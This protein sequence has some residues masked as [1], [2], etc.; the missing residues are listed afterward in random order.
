MPAIDEPRVQPLRHG[1]SPLAIVCFGGSLPFSVADAALKRGCPV[2]L[3]AVRGWADG[4]AVARYPHAWVGLGQFGRMKRL[5]RTAGCGDVVCIGNVVRPS[6]RELRLDWGAIRL[7]P[8][9][10]RLFRGGDDH[11]LSGIKG[12]MEE[13]GFRVLGAHEVAPEILVQ[14]GPLSRKLPSPQA[15]ADA[16]RGFALLEAI[17]AFDV[18]QAVVVAENRVL[19][20][21][22]ADGTDAMLARIAE[23]RAA[24]RIQLPPGVGVLVKAPKSGQDHRM[25]LPS[26]GPETV[27]G[28]RKAGLGGIAVRAGAVILA[29][30][31]VFAAAA[32]AAGIFV[33]GI[34]VGSS[35]RPT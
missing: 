9:L 30:P 2:F 19:A 13:H 22:A 32:D 21:E 26:I 33:V 8:R 27:A 28:V 7:L 15:R 31:A 18:G 35:E 4:E 12:I 6:L 17:G 11:L 20:I 3:L 14:E 29:E 23:L 16:A 5:A 24:G 34:R 25:D 1:A 10:Y